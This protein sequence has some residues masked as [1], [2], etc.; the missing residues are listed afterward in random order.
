MALL[1]LDGFNSYGS[2]SGYTLPARVIDRRWPVCYSVSA[3]VRP[4]RVS[5]YAL[6][7]QSGQIY[8][9]LLP[10]TDTT[11]IVGFAFKQ[12]DSW[13]YVGGSHALVTL[14][15]AGASGTPVPCIYL[16]LNAQ[17]GQLCLIRDFNPDTGRVTLVTVNANLLL[18]RWTYIELKIVC[19]D[20]GSYEIRVNG[21]SLA[22]GSADTKRETY[23]YHNCV[24]LGYTTILGQHD[25]WFDDL[26]VCDGAG[27]V[28]NDFL[29]P[30]KVHT[31]YPSADV[32]GSK[33][34]TPSTGVDHYALLDE[35]PCTDDTDYVETDGS[36]NLDLFE[37]QD[38]PSNIGTIKA[39]QVCTDVR[40]TDA[41]PFA[42][43]TVAK[44][45]TQTEN[46]AEDVMGVSYRTLLRLMETDTEGA[47]WTKA[48][49]DVTQFGIKLA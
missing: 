1:W 37:Y 48:N 12:S 7:G 44:R 2:S 16:W 5:Q 46:A 42:L 15:Y 38:S 47:S 20:S 33:D 22:S 11:L 23:S 21:K 41:E 29:G 25:D 30:I 8:R 27:S 9:A 6:K 24:A 40:E 19:G 14:F 10:T 13:G 32:V 18:H 49:L 36:G 43:K 45:T 35:N 31:L 3:E 17:T 4:G 28:N 34:W 26:Y 39:I